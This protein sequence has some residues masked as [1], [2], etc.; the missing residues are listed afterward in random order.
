MCRR[1]TDKWCET[2]ANL[3]HRSALAC[4]WLIQYLSGENGYQHIRLVNNMFGCTG[5]LFLCLSGGSVCV[6]FSL[7]YVRRCVFKI[8][9]LL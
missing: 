2:L 7:L 9:I 5:S 3:L 1:E 4:E 6:S 8:W